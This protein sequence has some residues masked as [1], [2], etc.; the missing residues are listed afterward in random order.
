MTLG[1]FSLQ[2]SSLQWTDEK[3]AKPPP[4]IL[5]KGRLSW[6]SLLPFFFGEISAGH[7]K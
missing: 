7:L 2:Y 1:M 4:K 6:E 3:S 5:A